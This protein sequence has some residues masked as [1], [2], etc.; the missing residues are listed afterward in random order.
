MKII[1]TRCHQYFP[2]YHIN[3]CITG[4]IPGLC[5][6]GDGL[7]S[8]DNPCNCILDDVECEPLD[9]IPKDE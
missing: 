3:E 4:N 6:S 8:F 5:D 1:Q 9:Y 2:T 7:Y